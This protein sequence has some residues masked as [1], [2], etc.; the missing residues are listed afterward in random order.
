MTTK[1][2]IPFLL[3]LFAAALLA[4]TSLAAQPAGHASLVIHHQTKGCHSWSLN[5]GAFKATQTV[6]LR[7]G[8]Y[9]TV[10]DND[11]M[12][13]KLIETSGPK[14]LFSSKPLSKMGATL[15]VSFAKAGTYHFTTKAGEDYMKGVKTVGEDNVLRLTVKVS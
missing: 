7:R 8:G 10:T 3:I 9:L 2:L 11:V 4:S 1:H 12:S 5:N 14:A 6:T 13:H 15:K